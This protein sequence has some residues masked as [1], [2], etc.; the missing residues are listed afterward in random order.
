MR[1]ID[2]NASTTTHVF[3]PKPGRRLWK[4]ALGAIKRRYRWWWWWW[5]GGCVG[6][7]HEATRVRPKQA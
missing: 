2:E 1:T 3:G 5:C 6:P 7:N 4:P